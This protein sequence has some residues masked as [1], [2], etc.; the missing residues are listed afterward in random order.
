MNT[1][2]TDRTTGFN[3]T[4][5]GRATI[6][7]LMLSAIATG[8]A[9]AAPPA[10]APTARVRF[11]DLNLNTDAGARTLY[12]RIENAAALVCPDVD[13]RELAR[14]AHGR[15]CQQDAVERAVHAIGSPKLAAVYAT[16]TRRG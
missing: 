10:D 3:R 5:A 12:R 7:V 2:K 6:A 15:A 14:A 16:A 1:S 9:V 13:S 11:A 4:A 8:T